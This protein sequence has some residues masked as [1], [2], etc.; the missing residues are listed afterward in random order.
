MKTKVLIA[1]PAVDLALSIEKTL[2]SFGLQTQVITSSRQFDGFDD[3]PFSIKITDESFM[4]TEGIVICTPDKANYH[5]QQ[6]LIP[7]VN[8]FTSDDLKRL[9]G[10]K[11]TSCIIG[12]STAIADLR[13]MIAKLA[14]HAIPVYIHGETGVGKELVATDLHNLSGRQGEFVRINCAGFTAELLNSELFGHVKGAFTGADRN[15]V[16]LVEVANGGTLFLDEVGDMPM[17]SQAQL[18]RLL[19]DGTYFKVGETKAQ[20]TSA[21]IVCATHHSLSKLVKERKFREDLY[22]RLN[23]FTINVPALR[24]RI[25]DLPLLLKT[26]LPDV[27]LTKEAVQ[28]LTRLSWRGNVRELKQ[29]CQRL[30]IFKEDNQ[31]D[32]G[33]VR[34]MLNAPDDSV[35]PLVKEAGDTDGEAG[36]VLRFDSIPDKTLVMEQYK[37]HV[38]TQYIDGLYRICNGNVSEMQK[39]SGIARATLIS[40]LQKMKPDNG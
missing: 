12:E 31:V 36:F 22:Y 4:P 32:L 30:D 37:T 23:G 40:Y 1:T 3:S 38:L 11:I 10:L 16:G 5:R 15:K 39:V 2:K 19:Q 28:Y 34:R 17:Q 29:L 8:P 33:L 27:D 7:L 26:F 6:K 18:L 35:T 21:R 25:D 20:Y 13:K 24:D 9:L 14:P